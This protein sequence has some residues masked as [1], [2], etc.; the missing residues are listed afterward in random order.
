MYISLIKLTHHA[1]SVR[2]HS[3][4]RPPGVSV[5]DGGI[6]DYGGSRSRPASAALSLGWGVWEGH[7]F[8]T[9]T[10]HIGVKMNSPLY[11]RVKF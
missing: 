2:G 6:E 1:F 10:M 8:G 3:G 5:G 4:S 9:D 11:F 7:L